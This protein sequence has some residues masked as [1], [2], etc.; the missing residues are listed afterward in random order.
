MSVVN[1]KTP[2]F[3]GDL[4]P[5]K[6]QQKKDN[7]NTSLRGRDASI[8][9]EKISTQSNSHSVR[10]IP[11]DD[12]PSRKNPQGSFSRKKRPEYIDSS[13]CGEEENA[14]EMSIPIRESVSKAEVY[15]LEDVFNPSSSKKSKT[16]SRSIRKEVKEL[17]EDFLGSESMK[18][19][20]VP[21]RS[22]ISNESTLQGSVL[23][24]ETTMDPDSSKH[25]VDTTKLRKHKGQLVTTQS[26]KI[27]LSTTAFDDL[28]C[29]ASIQSRKSNNSGFASKSSLLRIDSARDNSLL[30]VSYNH[31]HQSSLMRYDDQESSSTSNNSSSHKKSISRSPNV[32]R[33][34][35]LIE[36]TGKNG[37]R[38]SIIPDEVED[39]VDFINE[40]YA[41]LSKG[42]CE[43]KMTT[44]DFE[45][46]VSFRARGLG[47][48]DSMSPCVVKK[49]R[50]MRSGDEENICKGNECTK[51][52]V[53]NLGKQQET[54]TKS[55]NR[56][57]SATRK[58]VL[59]E[60][61]KT[62]ESN[63]LREKPVG[64]GGNEIDL[65]KDIKVLASKLS[66]AAMCMQTTIAKLE[67][68]HKVY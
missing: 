54:G 8:H 46:A 33:S 28:S 31:Q 53:T 24:T 63:V 17:A 13:E 68:Y 43:A 10:M 67:K 60:P 26:S 22:M 41:K 12:P 21:R 64:R 38:A 51:R 20:R 29:T 57:K 35:K 42:K 19:T 15:E 61:L 34:S 55:V 39:K 7:S 4:P 48:S 47:R 58:E 66:E 25:S 2:K 18:G 65:L 23:D 56:E 27:K 37:R 11:N 6:N 1:N 30:S 9:P 52:S 14:R 5:R 3:A 45:S 16:N 32:T 50:T 36:C 59:R 62:K 40:L 44:N 49:T